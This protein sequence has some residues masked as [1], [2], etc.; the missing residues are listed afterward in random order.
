MILLAGIAVSVK[1]VDPD[2]ITYG[3]LPVRLRSRLPVLIIVNVFAL[4]LPT[5]T[6]PKSVSSARL[7]VVSLSGILFPS[8][9]ISISG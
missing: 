2:S 3:E 7:G 6:D 9:V 1:L 5:I 8:P 4:E